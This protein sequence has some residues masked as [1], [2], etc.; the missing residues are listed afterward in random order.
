MKNEGQIIR[1]AKI[2][3]NG[4]HVFV[5]KGWA[6]EQIVLVKPQK[7]DLRERIFSA[8][9]PYLESIIG[10][11]LFGSYARGEQSENSDIDL[12]VI[13]DKKIKIGE[14][15]FE[16]TC[17]DQKEIEKAVKFEPI[18]LYSI[19]S[20]AKPII[21]SKLLDEL[22]STYKISLNDFNE[23]F[24][25]CK[26]MI[27]VNKEFLEREETEFLL[28]EAV[29][30]SVVLRIR[31][32]FIIQSLLKGKK[33]SHKLFKSWIKSRLPKIDFNSIY[34]AYNE[35][36]NEKKI[37][38]KIKIKDIKLLLELLIKEISLLENG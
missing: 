19:L 1:I 13:A 3:G 32:L 30:Y 26:R 4:A 7:K 36:K 11:Y 25:D 35:S 37:K 9:N 38:Q 16:V 17:L 31:G 21:N 6:G 34:T 2:F 27:K 15:D 5:P 23:F 10:I 8:L 14:K 28:S 33:Y 24:E 18:L 12:F 29:I 20:E 22:R